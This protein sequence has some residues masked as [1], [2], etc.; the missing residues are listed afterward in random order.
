[1]GQ[2]IKFV[3]FLSLTGFFSCK[4]VVDG[5]LR[6]TTPQKFIVLKNVDG[7]EFRLYE[8]KISLMLKH[9]ILHIYQNNLVHALDIPEHYH[10]GRRFFYLGR[11]LNQPLN[12]QG[13]SQYIKTNEKMEIHSKSCELEGLKK[14]EA[15]CTKG[16]CIGTIF[17]KQK[18]SHYIKKIALRFY[19]PTNS[20]KDSLVQHPVASFSGTYRNSL[21]TKSDPYPVTTP[22]RSKKVAYP[23]TLSK[24][25]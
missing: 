9:N 17:I 18:K 11:Q 6:I 5:K 3:A 25:Q 7:E 14:K 19:R 12:I 16:E 21:V 1:M 24:T 15:N 23:H 22:C 4:T 8:G 20:S 10:P 13:V 2:W